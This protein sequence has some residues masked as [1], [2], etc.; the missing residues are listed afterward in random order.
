MCDY[1]FTYDNNNIIYQL[2][3][4]RF[5][6]LYFLEAT[7]FMKDENDGLLHSGLLI[8]PKIRIISNINLKVG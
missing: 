2:K 6:N 8:M 5:N 4:E 1:Y 3:R 7:F